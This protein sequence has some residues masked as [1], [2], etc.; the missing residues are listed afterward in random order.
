VQ[1]RIEKK[2]RGFYIIKG[3]LYILYGPMEFM[4]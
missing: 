1:S 4:T 3:A 2:G